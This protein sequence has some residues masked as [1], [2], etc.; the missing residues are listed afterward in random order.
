MVTRLS[1]L[2]LLGII[3]T[4]SF[5]QACSDSGSKSES[6]AKKDESRTDNP[7]QKPGLLRLAG[8]DVVTANHEVLLDV[9]SQEAQSFSWK[10]VEGPGKV[11]FSKPDAADT[12]V[13]ADA[14][15]EYLLQLQASDAHGKAASLNV[16]F[17]WDT[18]GPKLQVSED[19]RA[20][21]KILIK[22]QAGSD[23]TGF[24]WSK[25]SGPGSIT[26][27]NADA[28]ETNVIADQ[29]GVYVLEFTAFDKLGNASRARTKL[30]WE[31]EKPALDLGDDIITNKEVTVAPRKTDA[32][33][34]EWTMIQGPGKVVFSHANS[35]TTSVKAAVDG[36]YTL[37][38]TATSALGT[39]QSEEVKLT[40]DTIAPVLTTPDISY[41]SRCTEDVKPAIHVQAAGADV[42]SWTTS[43][44]ASHRF[45][46]PKLPDTRFVAADGTYELHLAAWDLAGNQTSVKVSVTCDQTPPSLTLLAEGNQNNQK[47]P[48][49]L[50]AQTEES[51]RT[52]WV[53]KPGSRQTLEITETS[54]SL[55]RIIEATADGPYTVSVT[56]I[57][58]FGNASSKDYSFV[59]N[60]KGPVIAPG[61]LVDIE[62]RSEK[63]FEP[64]VENATKYQWTRIE[65]SDDLVI[66]SEQTRMTV[67]SAPKDGTWKV[68][69]EAFDDEGSKAVQEFK[70]TFDN[71]SPVVSGL[72]P[73]LT[74]KVFALAPQVSDASAAVTYV[75]SKV[76]GPG[77]L[78]FSSVNKANT[79]VKVDADGL[80]QVRLT[81]TD[82]AGNEGSQV[83]ALTWDA[84][85]PVI[86]MVDEIK[87]FEAVE[88]KPT[89]VDASPQLTYVWSKVSGQG[90]VSF[91]QPAAARTQVTASRNGTYVLRLSVQDEAGNRSSKDVRLVWNEAKPMIVLDKSLVKT[92][93]TF[94]LDAQTEGARTFLWEKVT[95][96]GSITFSN[97]TGEDTDVTAST[98]GVYE[99]R[100][101]I[102][103]DTDR[104]ASETVQITIDS[105]PP[106]ITLQD[107]L[108][109]AASN[110]EYILNPT[111]KEAATYEWSM[112][113]GPGSL[114]FTNA[115]ALSTTVKAS[116]AGTYRIKLIAKDSAGNASTAIVNLEWDATA[117][118]VSIGGDVSTGKPYKP[119]VQTSPDVVRYLWSVYPGTTAVKIS[120]YN[121]AE[122]IISAT[123]QGHYRIGLRVW[124]RAGNSSYAEF[125]MRWDMMA[126]EIHLRGPSQANA[127]FVPDV[128]ANEDVSYMWSKVSGPGNVFFSNA[129]SREPSISASNDGSYTIEVKATDLAGN[130]GKAS[131]VFHWIGEA[132]P[133]LTVD[134]AK[135]L[136]APVIAAD[137]SIGKA[138]FMPL[139]NEVLAAYMTRNSE[140][141]SGVYIATIDSDGRRSTVLKKIPANP[142]T[143]VYAESPLRKLVVW[144]ERDTSGFHDRTRV[145]GLFISTD[146]HVS[147][148]MDLG[149]SSYSGNYGLNVVWIKDRF[150]VTWLA[151]GDNLM[152]SRLADD[153]TIDVQNKL[154]LE[155]VNN[156][157]AMELGDALLIFKQTSR[158]A[159]YQRF[160][161]EGHALDETAKDLTFGFGRNLTFLEDDDGILLGDLDSSRDSPKSTLRLA[162]INKDGAYS[163]IQ[164]DNMLLDEQ[165]NAYVQD[166]K[167]I[168]TPAQKIVGVWTTQKAVLA[169]PLEADATFKSASIVSWPAAAGSYS[170]SRLLAASWG[171]EVLIGYP[172]LNGFQR[173]IRLARLKEE[174]GLDLMGLGFLA[175]RANSQTSLAT[176]SD[177]T[178]SLSV[179]CDNR[180]GGSRQ[181]MAQLWSNAGSPVWSSPIVIA[182][183]P[184]QGS[185]CNDPAVSFNG[186]NYIVAWTASNFGDSIMTTA[187]SKG[188][189][190]YQPEGQI[191][192]K[193][194]PSTNINSL[195]QPQLVSTPA[196]ET[197]VI[198]G[199][200]DSYQAQ[201]LL[202]KKLDSNG[203]ILRDEH[204]VLGLN[205]DGIHSWKAVFNG[206]KIVLVWE[207]DT[208][209]KGKMLA[210][211]TL[212]G[213]D[214]TGLIQSRSYRRL[215]LTAASQGEVWLSDEKTIQRI[216]PDGMIDATRD[217]NLK[218]LS[219]N[220]VTGM[221]WTGKSLLVS[222]QDY[223]MDIA[224]FRILESG[225]VASKTAGGFDM[226][227]II[228][229][230]FWDNVLFTSNGK[231]GALLFRKKL[232][233]SPDINAYRIEVFSIRP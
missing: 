165:A 203:R 73:A 150:V 49:A 195:S 52:S 32:A 184:V 113:S 57:D 147:D 79:E 167:L 30:T 179:W 158:G 128:Y 2:G 58:D 118:T 44:T 217:I 8:P 27:E 84:T 171:R 199:A 168:R 5:W 62:T 70:L 208:G 1:S 141:A 74:N 48:F 146:K 189:F 181:I 175:W 107:M 12:L 22:A 126:P 78:S 229:A 92:A 136:D 214:L 24:H 143:L 202:A 131:F 145:K 153:G 215:W 77:N 87:A 154:L 46:D 108:V 80:Y 71:T 155:N 196:G 100:L 174:S 151:S 129:T 201:Q 103:T 82:K 3:L 156:P 96:P 223:H 220:N 161:T 219:S 10:Q 133:P 221:V 132:A 83:Y 17:I 14:D 20:S 6:P 99:L 13:S 178:S 216:A 230:A 192:A 114:T 55:R 127:P 121:T 76:A 207:T 25:V 140:V 120:S 23:A 7:G 102:K 134:P 61:A 172:E 11:R 111:V 39:V 213:N 210:P 40:W 37:R 125:E 144:D 148:V 53:V 69:F 232:D 218:N 142:Q 97:P 64:A 45:T 233:E 211:D 34:Y 122:T 54:N 209:F 194:R 185:V 180:M 124:D 152:M 72:P 176:A 116:V 170:D 137:Y 231:G 177:G 193:E 222:I 36:V 9:S 226:D 15:G 112:V 90:D 101:S 28:K 169:A 183:P 115:A 29:D 198:Y 86:T 200:G 212:T 191:L 26:F 51:A 187:I 68:R 110:P 188:G 228:E 88:L 38:L 138:V 109:A 91:T 105:T 173:T 81:A 65:G 75:W 4:T 225:E 117:P 206:K 163:L 31:A 197:I 59:W 50:I 43:S 42:F 35:A 130:E 227:L 98:D 63:S 67:I 164:K 224:M 186:L 89:A 119:N 205:A 160:T 162:R 66:T 18:V 33:H 47:A 93:K 41:L 21:S 166:F 157:Q 106:V 123:N 56:A 104:E 19:R 159:Q 85:A 190:V 60:A 135:N 95:G 139:G 204:Q 16:V 94:G 149:V 182:K